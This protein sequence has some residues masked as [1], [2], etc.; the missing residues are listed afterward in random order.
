MK[1]ASQIVLINPDGLILG[2]SRKDNHNDIGFPGGKMELM[3]E[4]DPMKTAIRECK[5]ET[6][7]D[8]TNLRLIFAMCHG[9]YMCYTYLADYSGEIGTDEPHIIKWVAMEVLENGGYGKYNEYVRNSMLNYGIKFKIL[10][11]FNSL[12]E[13]VITL[14]KDDPNFTELTR[15]FFGGIYVVDFDSMNIDIDDKTI[16]E[17]NDIGREF[18]VK[19]TVPSFY[20]SK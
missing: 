7:L 4:N 11:D 12:N 3:D 9:D 17:L 20:Y 14:F 13:R 10:I 8:I 18:G 1:V 6:G 19:I 2:V 5:E 15:D 16:S